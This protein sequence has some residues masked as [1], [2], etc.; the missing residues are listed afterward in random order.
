MELDKNSNIW[1][2]ISTYNDYEWIRSF[3]MYGDLCTL[4]QGFVRA[5]ICALL[6]Y[7]LGVSFLFFAVSGISLHIIGYFAFGVN[8]LD[9][10][11]FMGGY[12]QIVTFFALV[13][14]VSIIFSAFGIA[15]FSLIFYFARKEKKPSI[16]R[17][18]ISSKRNKYCALVTLVDKETYE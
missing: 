10:G 2:F 8:L 16:I 5:L 12:I 17:E 14:Y 1:K 18:Y 11:R 13:S 9:I 3:K 6:F 15:L 7:G 4:G